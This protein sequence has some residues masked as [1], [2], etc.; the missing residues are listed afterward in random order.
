MSRLVD[1]FIASGWATRERDPG[2]GR[3]RTVVITARGLAE[4][5]RVATAMRERHSRVF[6]AM[7]KGEREAVAVALP[8]LV[9]ALAQTHD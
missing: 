8:A 6:A 1:G 3:V 2:N 9:R 4:E 7:T 5:Q